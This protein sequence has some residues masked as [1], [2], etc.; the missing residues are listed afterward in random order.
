[1]LR[2]SFSVLHK[3]SIPMLVQN[4]DYAVRGPVAIRGIQ[5]K[6]EMSQG[7]KFKFDKMVPMHSGNPQA[8]NQPPITFG[9]EVLSLIAHDQFGQKA[10]FSRY[11]K[12]AIDRADFYL[13]SIDGRAFGAYAP[14]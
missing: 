4:A 13:K 11:S 3:K 9:R 12:D 2:R 7:K 8:L 5:I 1:M 6:G 10:D 14:H